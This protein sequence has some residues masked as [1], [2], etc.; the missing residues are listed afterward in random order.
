MQIDSNKESCKVLRVVVSVIGFVYF[1]LCYLIVYPA[2]WATEA[3]STQSWLIPSVV[4]P[5]QSYA[6]MML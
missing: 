1:L 3:F 5:A 4:K 6:M 2:G